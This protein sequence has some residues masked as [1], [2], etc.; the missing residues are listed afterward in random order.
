MA[1]TA[2]K[3]FVNTTVE[4]MIFDGEQLSNLLAPLDLG[5]KD[6][7][8]KE[9]ALMEELMPQFKKLANGGEIA[10]LSAYE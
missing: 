2:L 10:G 1:I 9:T 7:A 3:E 8:K 5:W 6:R 4:R